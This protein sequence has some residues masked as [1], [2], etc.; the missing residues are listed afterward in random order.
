MIPEAEAKDIERV[1]SLIHIPDLDLDL[2]I[3]EAINRVCARAATDALRRALESQIAPEVEAL[4]AQMY[5]AA[6]GAVDPADLPELA[7]RCR[8]AARGFYAPKGSP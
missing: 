3:I 5:A 1:R 7:R 4:A 6:A 8:S 2:N